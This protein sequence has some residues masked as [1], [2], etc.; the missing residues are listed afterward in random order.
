MYRLNS[1]V[2]WTVMVAGGLGAGIERAAAEP[3][4]AVENVKYQHAGYDEALAADA[5]D[6]EEKAK[7]RPFVREMGKIGRNDP[8]PCGSGKKYK[9]CHGKLT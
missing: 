8:C 1:L 9:Q 5:A 2:L 6:A 3:V 4:S 7:E